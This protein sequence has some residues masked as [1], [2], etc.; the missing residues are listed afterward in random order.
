M[1]TDRCYLQRVKDPD[2]VRLELAR[3]A[4]D[5]LERHED[6]PGIVPIGRVTEAARTFGVPFEYIFDERERRARERRP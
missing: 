6:P 1:T 4:C 3:Q 5:F 2:P